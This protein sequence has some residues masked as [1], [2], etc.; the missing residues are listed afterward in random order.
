MPHGR[1]LHALLSCITGHVPVAGGKD[2]FE[3]REIRNNC[4]SDCCTGFLY[5]VA[6]EVQVFIVTKNNAVM[7][8][9]H[10]SGPAPV[11]QRRGAVSVKRSKR[12]ADR[13]ETAIAAGFTAAE[14]RSG[15]LA[16]SPGSSYSRKGEANCLRQH[17]RL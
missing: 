3:D 2:Y 7:Q 13:L 8:N 5:K 1:L 9:W 14:R 12:G 15:F 10:H 16:R 17:L 11:R 4:L 6:A